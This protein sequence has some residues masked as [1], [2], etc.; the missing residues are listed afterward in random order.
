M[1]PFCLSILAGQP[2]SV[3][4][5]IKPQ[6]VGNVKLAVKAQ[7]TTQADA[8]ERILIVKPEGAEREY[9]TSKFLDIDES[10]GASAMLE[11]PTA[12]PT[13][14]GLV[15]GSASI[16]FSATADL[17]GASID[18]LDRLV[19]LPTGCGEQASDMC[20]RAHTETG[21]IGTVVAFFYSFRCGVC[22][23]CSVLQSIPDGSV[24]FSPHVFD[25]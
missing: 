9:T 8:S 13:D 19:R 24:F 18:G 23:S 4:F 25:E 1:I 15:P 10:T 5:F 7:S 20:V 6:K 17:M 2:C 12:V 22:Y 21:C 14:T 11:L 3:S 16:R